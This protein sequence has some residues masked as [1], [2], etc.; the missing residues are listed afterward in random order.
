MKVA[1]E[2]IE[3]V[4]AAIHAHDFLHCLR[5]EIEQLQKVVFH[6]APRVDWKLARASAEQILAAEIITRHKG[7]IDGVYFALRDR[8]EGGKPWN[9]ALRELAGSIHSYFTTPLGIVMRRDLFGAQA[10]YISPEALEWI[11][12]PVGVST[13]TEK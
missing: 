3:A 7:E 5:R 4:T 11:K 6:D 12:A 10:V 13:T 8:E 9:A 1:Q 2:R